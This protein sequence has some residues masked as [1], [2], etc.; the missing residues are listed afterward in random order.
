MQ[1]LG[2]ADAVENLDAE[3]IEEALVDA[4]RQRLAGRYG[5]PHRREIGLRAVGR[6]EKRR[7]GGR[8]AEENHRPVTPYDVEDRLRLR[9]PWIQDCRGADGKGHIQ[10]ITEA[11][12]K[13]E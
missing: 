1:N 9:T 13:E 3:A 11:I 12:G 2:R 4:G 10:R 5:N 7:V 8:N 6:L